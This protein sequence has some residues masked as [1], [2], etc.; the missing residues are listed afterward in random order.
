MSNEQLTQK[1]IAGESQARV[2]PN[3]QG[4]AHPEQ[5]SFWLSAAIKM[6]K[7]VGTYCQMENTENFH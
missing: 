7:K 3:R 4:L 5:M 2:A 1:T 6:R